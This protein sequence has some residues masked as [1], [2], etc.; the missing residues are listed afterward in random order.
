MEKFDSYF[1]NCRVVSNSIVP[2][3]VII[4]QFPFPTFLFLKS[5]GLDQ[6]EQEHALFRRSMDDA[7]NKLGLSEGEKKY[8]TKLWHG[9]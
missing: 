2:L 6:D 8:L 1:E 3:I 7:M 5:L 9:N 4:S